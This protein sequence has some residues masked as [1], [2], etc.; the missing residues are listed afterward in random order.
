[1][2]N[3]GVH[4]IT[5]N[6]VHKWVLTSS[7][8]AFIFSAILVAS[9]TDSLRN[10]SRVTRHARGRETHDE[11]LREFAWEA[12]ILDVSCNP[13]LLQSVVSSCQDFLRLPCFLFPFRFS[14]TFLSLLS[15]KHYISSLILFLDIDECKAIPK[16][17]S[18]GRCVNSIGS[19]R[20][21][22]PTGQKL[23]TDLQKCVGR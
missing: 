23:D 1:M 12:T 18:G 22:C 19:Y 3:L 13:F 21:E 5:Y 20:C 17:C 15:P 9:H 4:R 8:Q 6:S 16:I 7:R 11:F 14:L 10:S 2:S